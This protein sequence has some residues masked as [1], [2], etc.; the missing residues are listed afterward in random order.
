L[1]LKD[2]GWSDQL[3]TEFE[4]FAA[5]GLVPARVTEEHRG[6][7]VLHG[8]EGELRAEVAPRLRSRAA[9][10]ADFPAVGDWVALAEGDPPL[11]HA[12]LPRRTKFSRKIA[13]KETDEQVVAANVDVVFL[14]TALGGD[15]N[16]RRL[17]R[18][19]VTAWESGAQP[20]VVLTKSD[21]ADDV[22][23]SVLEAEAIAFGVPIHAVSAVTGAGLD[24]LRAYV[25]AGRTVALLGSSGVGKSTL[26]NRFA[27]HEL[28]RT[29]ELRADGRG[30]H[31]T[32]HRELVPLPGGGLVL[33][34][35]GM[36]ELQLWE[37]PEGLGEAFADV[38]ELARRCRFAD[39]AHRTEP[40]CAIREAIR[41]G[42]LDPE[43]LASYE[44][45]KRELHYL[46]IRLDKRARAEERKRWR[47]VH[48]DA[49]ARARAK[50]GRRR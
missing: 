3:A 22:D 18:Y 33:D 14:V 2:L 45:L 19:L 36:R 31:T 21:L 12:V 30:R 26:V 37:S 4:P 35:P 38:E 44:K 41:T 27:G 42:S 47:Q 25:Q 23:G 48:R 16:A 28:L 34:T 6:A 11:V 15:F 24:E 43:R 39:C 10:R 49:R 20:V 46:E 1:N 8:E 17:E 40:G 50:A 32:T 29:A 9:G 13:F 5:E 7:Y